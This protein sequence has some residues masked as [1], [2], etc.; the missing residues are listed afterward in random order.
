MSGTRQRGNRADTCACTSLGPICICACARSRC[1]CAERVSVLVSAL[2]C[3][4]HVH[5]HASAQ[6]GAVCRSLG[7]QDRHAACSGLGPSSTK[8]LK[9]GRLWHDDKLPASAHDV[10]LP[11]SSARR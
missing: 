7:A 6:G 1:I 5:W 10:K 4:G 11:A 8:T 2:R 9:L 3:V